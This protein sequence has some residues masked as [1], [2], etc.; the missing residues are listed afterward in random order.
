[1][2]FSTYADFLNYFESSFPLPNQRSWRLFQP[3]SGVTTRIVAALQMKAIPMVEWQKL[4]P[5]GKS[6]GTNGS[7]SFALLTS[8]PM[9]GPI[10]RTNE[11]TDL[12]QCSPGK[13]ELEAW[14]KAKLSKLTVSAK[15]SRP[16]TIPF[17]WLR[18][19]TPSKSQGQTNL[20]LQ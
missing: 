18:E 16:L 2:E 5:H 8:T 13:F 14:V 12:Q 9:S 17:P 4:P 20:F 10:H 19:E 11:S 1:M 7:S 3:S 6:I 15:G